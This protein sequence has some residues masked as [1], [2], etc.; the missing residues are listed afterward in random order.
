MNCTNSSLESTEFVTQSEERR[1][2]IKKVDIATNVYCINHNG[3]RVILSTVKIGILQP[4]SQERHCRASLLLD[5]GSQINLVTSELIQRLKLPCNEARPISGINR[6]VTKVNKTTSIRIKS[7]NNDFIMTVD[8]LVVPEITEQLPQSQI[9]TAKIN[10]PKYVKLTD[11]TYHEPG[12]IDMLLGA[13]VYWKILIGAPENQIK[14]RPALQNTQL[15]VII[16]ELEEKHANESDSC[17]VVTNTQLQNQLQRFWLQEEVPETQPYSKEEMLCEE[18]FSKTITQQKDGR[19][20]VRLPI[21]THISLGNSMTQAIKRLISLERRFTKNPELKEAYSEFLKE[22]LQQGHMSLIENQSMLLEQEHY[23]MP[24]QPVVR[25][26][27]KTTKLRVV[28]DASSRTTNSMSLNNKLMPGPNLQADLQKILIRFRTQEFVLTADITSMFR[29][30]LVDHRDRKWQLI[31]WREET[32]QSI[33][34]YQL[35]TIT[36]GTACAPFLAMRCLRELAQIYK[37]EFPL[38]AK[39]V[40]EDFYMDDV[41]TGGPSLKSVIT[42]QKQLS[43]MLALGKLPLRKWRANHK[44]I[45]KHLT[46]D[47]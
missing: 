47:K 29:Q 15:G 42:L 32:T 43:E 21:R 2:D 44:N 6:T 23:I 1:L 26:E 8:C 4:N 34:L 30:I 46:E 22:Y 7:I 20:V 38:A 24:H 27:S 17:N 33:Q 14:G 16:G 31:L 3:T 11:P 45:L 19:F 9:S 41:L 40:E 37:Q 35:N 5:P 13:G 10:I 18:L 28:F 12:P 36:Y 39:A 25:P